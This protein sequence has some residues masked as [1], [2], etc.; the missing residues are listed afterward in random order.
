MCTS[1]GCPASVRFLPLVAVVAAG[2]SVQSA[3]PGTQPP[4]SRPGIQIGEEGDALP[5]DVH[6]VLLDDL[7]TA[8]GALSYPPRALK[9]LLALDAV[10]T[11]SPTGGADEALEIRSSAG[12]HAWHETMT[13]LEGIDPSICAGERYLMEVMVRFTTAELDEVFVALGWSVTEELG[14]W[15]G[16]IPL[17]DV[18]GTLRPVG[19]DPTDLRIEGVATGGVWDGS[20]SWTAYE[21]YPGVYE[22]A[23]S[24]TA[25]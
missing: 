20:V 2:C 11:F 12:Q 16:S 18:E 17:E 8:A 21:G 7:E 1:A 22:P 15:V 3:P 25:P 24:W 5:C 14:T 13:P 4:P 23:G 10:G 19:A 6:V 9:Q